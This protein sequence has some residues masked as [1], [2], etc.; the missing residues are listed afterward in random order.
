MHPI[1]VEGA[2]YEFDIDILRLGVIIV[3]KLKFV[4]FALKFVYTLDNLKV[5]N[6]NLAG[7]S[8]NKIPRLILSD[9]EQVN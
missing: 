4:K 2:E 6:M 7:F 5:I 8:F 3:S 1:Q 9:F